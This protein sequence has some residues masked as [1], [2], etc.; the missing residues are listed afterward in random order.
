MCFRIIEMHWH[1]WWRLCLL[2]SSVSLMLNSRLWGLT[3]IVSF[4]LNWYCFSR[5][6]QDPLRQELG[7]LLE[8]QQT[9]IKEREVSTILSLGKRKAFYCLPGLKV[10]F[11]QLEKAMKSVDFIG[12]LME[13]I[14][15]PP[16]GCLLFFFFTWFFLIFKR[17]I[18]S[19][20]E[21]L[22]TQLEK[23]TPLKTK[24]SNLPAFFVFHYD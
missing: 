22:K 16:S 24:I 1:V 23:F 7:K 21:V 18:T 3:P 19:V 11:S 12:I 5:H 10:E 20:L 15:M 9:C 14:A 2:W 13:K 17:C 8:K 6:E 4:E